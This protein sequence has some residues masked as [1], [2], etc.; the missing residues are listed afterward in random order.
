ME[1]LTPTERI[2][3]NKGKR[4]GKREGKLE[5]KLELTLKQLVRRV[6]D[7]SAN[8]QKQLRKLSNE[9]LDELA[10]ALF[11]FQSQRELNQWLKQQHNQS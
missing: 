8:V 10:L 4:E 11:D 5:G 3:F 9:Q 7:L 1:Y 6:G 2:G